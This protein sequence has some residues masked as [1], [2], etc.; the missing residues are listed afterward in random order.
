MPTTRFILCEGDGD[1]AFFRNLI[2]ARSIPNLDVSKRK[3]DDV[4]GNS[5][6]KS[7]LQGLKAETSIEACELLIIVADNDSDPTAA[8][9]D[10]QR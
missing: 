7:R 4:T 3:K 9:A 10:V 6:F 8:F 5:S 1:D 2:K